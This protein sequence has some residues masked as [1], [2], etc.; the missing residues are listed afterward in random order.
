MSVDERKVQL[1]VEVDATRARQ[2]F[3]EVKD[4]A[5]DMAQGVTQAGQQAGKGLDQI[6][7]GGDQ[8][9][10]KLDRSTKSIIASIQRTTAAMEAGERG[11][12]KYYEAIAAQRGANTEALRPYLE[13]LDAAIEKQKQA[14][15]GFDSMGL[16]AAQQAAALRNI[17]AQFTDIFTSLASGQQPMTVLL[18]QGGQLKDMFGGAGNA[19]KALG[20]YVLSLLTPVTVIAAAVGA[21]AVAYHQGAEESNALAKSIIL[22]GNA[23]NTSV[24]QLQGVAQSVATLTG[25]TKGAV[26]EALQQIAGTGKVSSEAIGSVAEAAIR[27]ERAAGKAISETV[28]EFAELGRSPVEA[29][30][31]LDEQYN[32]LTADIY[33]QIKALEDHGKT[34]DAAALAQKTF[35]DAMA[36][37]SKEIAGNLGSLE[38]AWKAV[39]DAAKGAWDR[40]LDVGRKKTPEQ[41]LAELKKQLARGGGWDFAQTEDDIKAQVAD[42]EKRIAGEK[43]ITEEKAKQNEQEQ[44]KKKWLDQQDKYLSRAQQQAIEIE[45][46]RNEGQA[47][48][49]SEREINARIAKVTRGDYL[50][51]LDVR[52]GKV[53]DSLNAQVGLIQDSVK[54]QTKAELDG[55]EEVKAARI[56]AAQDEVAILAKKYAASGDRNERD[57]IAAEMDKASASATRAIADADVQIKALED[58]HQEALGRFAAM[59]GESLTPLEQAWQ[60]FWNANSKVVEQ[61]QLNGWTDVIDRMHTAW[62]TVADQTNFNDAKARFSE[63][64]SEMQQQIEAVRQVA[65]RDGGFLGGLAAEQQVQEIRNKYIPA[66]N[67]LI[68]KMQEAKGISP[69]NE[70]TVVDA[71]R[72]TQKAANEISPVWKK[73][74]D[75]IERSLTDALYRGFESGKDFGDNFVK[76]LQNTFK[77]M[78]L[79]VAVQAIVSPVMGAVQQAVGINQTTSNALGTMNLLNSAGNI[80]R[81]FGNAAGAGAQAGSL[82]VSNVVGATGG[83]SLGAF[84][85]LNAAN[86][87]TEAGN[88]LLGTIG[89]GLGYFGAGLTAYGVAQKYGALGGMAAGAGSIALGGAAAGAL[90]I[91][92]AGATAAAA[93]GG[94]AGA[95]AAASGA[96]AAVPVWGWAALAALSIAGGMGSSGAPKVNVGG[97]ASMD[98]AKVNASEAAKRSGQWTDNFTQS[99]ADSLYS[100]A[101]VAIV[102]KINP[103][104][105]GSALLHGHLNIKGRSSNQNLA[106][107]LNG[108]GQSVYTHRT[109]TGKGTGDFQKFI[110]EELPRMNLAVVV[111]AMRSAGG[112]IKQIADSVMGSAT[113]LTDRLSTM[114]A[115][116]ISAAM[117]NLA[118]L[119]EIF[120]TLKA[121]DPSITGDAAVSLAKLAG[122]IQNLTAVIASY[123]DGFYSEEEKAARLRDQLAQQFAAINQVMPTTRDGFRKLVEGLNLTNEAD[124]RTYVSLMGMASAFGQ[125]ADSAEQVIEKTVQAAQKQLDAA[126]SGLERSVAAERTRLD[127]QYNAQIKPLKESAEA[128]TKTRDAIASLAD[129]LKNA[130]KSII[131]E[132]DE[133]LARRRQSA[134]DLLNEAVAVAQ[135]GGSLAPYE[136]KITAAIDDLSRPS[137]QLYASFEDYA[138]AQG[139]ANAALEKLKQSALAQKSV[140]DLTLEA[141]N[142]SILTADEQH[143]QDLERLTGILDAA[144]L[145]VDAIKG[146]D[147]SV[148]SLA[149]A[150][151]S[152]QSSL[153]SAR[154]VGAV[155][156]GN[157]LPASPGGTVNS[158]TA[159]GN[160]TQQVAAL[161][162]SALGREADVGGLVY[163]TGLADRSGGV[164][165]I[166]D[167]FRTAAVR[168]GEIPRFASGGDHF[169]GLRLVGENGPELEVTGP[170]RIYNAEQTKSLLGGRNDSDLIDEVRALQ[171]QLAALNARIAAM[172]SDARRTA[173]AINGNPESPMQ[174]EIAA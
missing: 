140:A 97:W 174:V 155:A 120:E 89:Q 48:G 30:R 146:V 38:T 6:G 16:S 55:I 20:G 172:Q 173:N 68:S 153:G 21:L 109:E 29:S 131:P 70:K 113:D 67:E 77:S 85:D 148:K 171:A 86:W 117:A 95:G 79:K 63:V 32:Y 34:S 162:E 159:A 101:T 122:G 165:A 50:Q 12:V 84:M 99:L 90:G 166:L 28:K 1:G 104:Y 115:A 114:G 25:A 87:G 59:A 14:Q 168:N 125:V 157:P 51:S 127:N 98:D 82:A 130:V 64:F 17:P 161:Y 80:S 33:K 19:A 52:L 7:T 100:A 102:K 57:R 60:K 160:T 41:E 75:D 43:R 58:K 4:A 10:Q 143:K 108:A 27:M 56:R 35:A 73:F 40:M 110:E 94:L 169:G 156:G 132:S 134:Q 42:L 2:G 111:D 39:S 103:D 66:L 147:S 93:G 72:Q 36:G 105:D 69:V 62:A 152:F 158:I 163:W 18:Q 53:R 88:Q 136:E 78:V 154:V 71:V 37:R 65:E 83:D 135:S 107:V 81:F 23:A 164:Q 13:Q 116:D 151:G 141:I 91:G 124:Q 139:E 144:R 138:V 11:T 49:A 128:A 170:A 76:T 133:L 8:S 46:I 3:N 129:K 118:G 142:Q 123:Y 167:D 54:Q 5:R 92:T 145:Q 119:A 47:A 31:K 121:I 22:S 44:A 96:L 137:A 112:G 126:Y 15:Q 150:M 74:S 45:R 26:T 9:A 24:S 106:E 61:A 149:D